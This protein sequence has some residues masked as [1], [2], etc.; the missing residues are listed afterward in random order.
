MMM[1]FIF[2]STEQMSDLTKC[3]V[4]DDHLKYLIILIPIRVIYVNDNIV[5]TLK[6]EYFMINQKTAVFNA[7]CSV[8]DQDSFDGAIELTKEERAQV[9]AIVAEGFATGEVELSD[10]A[11]AK[12][13]TDAKLKTY[14]NGL[15][16]NWVRKD[17]RLNGNVQ[18]TI[19]NPG[20]RAGSGDAVIRELKKLKSTFTEQDQ[21]NAVET[22]IEKRMAIIKAEKAKDVEIDMSL[23]PDDLKDLLG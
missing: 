5:I 13:S 10:N 14:T 21:I 23:I 11:R 22:E 1:N 8:L 20:S 7:T 16:S 19:K 2:G 15:V 17:K 9:I 12:Y 18:H 4:T 6:M 3:P